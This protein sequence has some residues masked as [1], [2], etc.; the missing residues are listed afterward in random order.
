MGISGTVSHQ[1]VDQIV[2][3][4]RTQLVALHVVGWAEYPVERILPAPRTRPRRRRFSEQCA[5]PSE[6]R[7][8]L[9]IVR[10]RLPHI[11]Q[12]LRDIRQDILG[13]GGPQEIAGSEPRWR[14]G[15]PSQAVPRDSA[16][17]RADAPPGRQHRATG[18]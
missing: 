4:D 17:Q 15:Q 10:E 16:L 9:S 12:P 6:C 5:L 3:Q 1:F 14:C 18:R 2:D 11:A 8:S 7:T 13:T